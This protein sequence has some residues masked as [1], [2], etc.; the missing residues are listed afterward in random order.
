MISP[1]AHNDFPYGYDAIAI[2]AWAIAVALIVFSTKYNRTISAGT[3]ARGRNVLR[4]VGM[5][6]Y[7]L[8]L[9]HYV[10]AGVFVLALRLL[11]LAI[12]PAICGGS[13]CF[14][15]LSFFIA[16][17]VEPALQAVLRAPLVR[18]GAFLRQAAPSLSF[19]FARHDLG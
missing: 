6:T 10:W 11:G 12:W 2:A 1:T 13:A 19:L 5:A 15:V 18:L 17:F 9:I 3:G 7:P 16:R 4:L 14:I 8:Y